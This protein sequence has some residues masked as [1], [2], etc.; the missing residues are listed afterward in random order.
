MPETIQAAPV[1]RPQHVR[2]PRERRTR[3]AL[4]LIAAFKFLKAATLIVAGLGALDLVRPSMAARVEGWLENL[5]LT[6]GH[7]FITDAA[8]RAVNALDSASPHRLELLALGAFLYAAVFLVE[9]VGLARQRRWA[10][11]LTIAVTLSF[12]PFEVMALVHRYTLPRL[13]TLIINGVVVLYLAW[14]LYSTR[15]EVH[16]TPD[17]VRPERAGAQ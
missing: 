1:A 6:Q 2:T 5:S 13:G 8:G 4:D 3:G 17:D 11:Y 10:E 12:M 7:Q 9:G 16:G 14:Q 15:H